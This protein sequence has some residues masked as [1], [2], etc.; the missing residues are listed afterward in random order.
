[1]G[2]RTRSYGP[3]HIANSGL[4][5]RDHDFYSPDGSSDSNVLVV[6]SGNQT[7]IPTTNIVL[8]N[9]ST[10]SKNADDG[11]SV[12]EST[13][14]ILCINCDFTYAPGHDQTNQSKGALL[15]TSSGVDPANVPNWVEFRECRFGAYIRNPD[16]EGGVVNFIDCTFAACA[17]T[18]VMYS[19][20]CNFIR[21]T[22]STSLKPFW[23][24][25]QWDSVTQLVRPIVVK[26]G[27]LFYFEACK[28]N[29]AVVTGPQLCR[30]W[31]ATPTDSDIDVSSSLFSSSRVTVA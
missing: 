1:M 19:A 24:D 15:A 27:G 4:H 22:F 13:S 17:R 31:S 25:N 12:I 21:C 29:G 9:V 28:L 5:V 6:W 11:F 20:R 18:C 10:R 30:E 14:N 8:E 7:T 3:A 2:F 16:V 26:D 23:A